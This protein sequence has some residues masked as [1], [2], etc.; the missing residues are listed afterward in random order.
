MIWRAACLFASSFGFLSVKSDSG[1]A[2]PTAGSCAKPG[3][4]TSANIANMSSVAGSF[5][6]PMLDG[7]TAV[8]SASRLRE[9]GPPSRLVRKRA[10]YHLP[11]S[12]YPLAFA[13][14]ENRLDLRG[15]FRSAVDASRRQIHTAR[16]VKCFQQTCATRCGRVGR[17]DLLQHLNEG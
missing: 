4:V 11:P 7:G 5:M 16:G 17:R 15:A 8:S 1:L 2:T 6:R 14:S 9:F 10:V 12:S 13:R 3:A